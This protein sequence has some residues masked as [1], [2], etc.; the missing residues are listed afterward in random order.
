MK[1]LKTCLVLII[2]LAL[3]VSGCNL[4]SQDVPVSSE[5][6]SLK[7]A[8]MDKYPTV[9]D[10]AYTPPKLPIMPSSKVGVDEGPGKVVF[11]TFDDGPSDITPGF[12]DILKENGVHAT[13]CVVGN[14]AEAFQDIIRRAH[15]E[16]HS[17]ICHSYDHDLKDTYGSLESVIESMERCN[18]SIDTI[19]KRTDIEKAFIRFPGGSGVKFLLDNRDSMA[20]ALKDKGYITLDWNVSSRDC[21]TGKTTVDYITKN[22][23]NDSSY[24]VVVL[25][26]HDF[27]YRLTTMEALPDI[28]KY[29]KDKGYAFKAISDMTMFE[30]NTLKSLK[31]VSRIN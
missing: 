28:I 18:A 8:E 23:T 2:L 9:Q 24:D 27:K 6:D 25:L 17:I 19:V 22:S 11:L 21:D 1:R 26:M 13:F 4:S 15:S 20:K 16:G 14:R 10:V 7:Q 12:L 5:L 3:Y 29:Y 30:L 31:V